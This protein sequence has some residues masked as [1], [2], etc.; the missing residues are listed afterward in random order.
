M[1]FYHG[2]STRDFLNLSHFSDILLLRH[3]AKICSIFD[4]H[5]SQLSSKQPSI[6]LQTSSLFGHL[7]FRG[8]PFIYFQ[9]LK[10]AIPVIVGSLFFASL[11]I[12]FLNRFSSFL[13]NLV[14]HTIALFSLFSHRISSH[15]FLWVLYRKL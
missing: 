5:L 8:R 10:E 1:E 3:F 12:A 7:Q 4:A 2:F 13:P 14:L 15:C 11:T 6:F 9:L